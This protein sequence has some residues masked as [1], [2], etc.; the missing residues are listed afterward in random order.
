[1]TVANDG[2]V[3]G[4][5]CHDCGGLLILRRSPTGGFFLGC[6]EYSKESCHSCTFT[7]EPN[8][9]EVERVKEAQAE[10]RI[11]RK[12]KK[13]EKLLR[14]KLLK[15]NKPQT[16]EVYLDGQKGYAWVLNQT[17]NEIR[18]NLPDLK[19]FKPIEEV[20]NWAINDRLHFA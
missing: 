10:R 15:H 9:D 6:S 4:S 14:K 13:I 7:M 3:S 17:F 16:I 2:S 18:F 12:R 20:V 1:M 19:G 8:S 5:P 11:E